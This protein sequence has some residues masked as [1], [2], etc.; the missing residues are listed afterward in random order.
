MLNNTRAAIARYPAPDD[1]IAK[2][3]QYQARMI[4]PIKY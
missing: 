3:L 2:L 1:L 4:V